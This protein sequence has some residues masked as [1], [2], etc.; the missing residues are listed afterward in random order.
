MKLSNFKE[1]YLTQFW[2]DLDDSFFN[3]QL[4]TCSWRPVHRKRGPVR[5]TIFAFPPQRRILDFMMRQMCSMGLK[6]GKF[7]GQSIFGISSF[8]RLRFV[9]SESCDG[10]LSSI[11]WKLEYMD[12]LSLHRGH[13][14]GLQRC[15]TYLHES[16]PLPSP[17]FI[18]LKVNFFP[19]KDY[20]V[21]TVRPVTFAT[22]R[23]SA[24]T[25]SSPSRSALHSSDCFH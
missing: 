7:T 11:N 10:V 6:S 14:I 5:N 17:N 19:Q 21:L 25:H 9:N 24:T 20:V 8:S 4:R 22:A 2:C 23:I 16:T 13:R 1:L 15:V 18:G 12:I 3:L